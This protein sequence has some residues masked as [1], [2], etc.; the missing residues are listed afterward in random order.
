MARTE[1]LGKGNGGREKDFLESQS[2]KDRE[3]KWKRY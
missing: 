2:R 3:K 1:A